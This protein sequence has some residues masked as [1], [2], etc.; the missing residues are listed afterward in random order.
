[1]LYEERSLDDVNHAVEQVLDG[2][3]TTP[4][5]VFRLAGTRAG[6]DGRIPASAAV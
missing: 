6:E 3:A 2:T 1:V 4:R 5:L